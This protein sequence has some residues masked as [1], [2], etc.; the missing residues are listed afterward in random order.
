MGIFAGVVCV[1][2]HKASPSMIALANLSMI[3]R[4]K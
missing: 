3:L 4:I 2:V 1:D